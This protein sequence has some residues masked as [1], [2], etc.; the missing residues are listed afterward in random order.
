MKTPLFLKRKWA[1]KAGLLLLLTTTLPLTA[2]TTAPLPQP[3]PMNPQFL[4]YQHNKMLGTMRQQADTGHALGYI[5]P[6]VALPAPTNIARNSAINTAL[7]SSYDLRTQNKLTPVRDQGACG[8]CWAH[9]AYSSLESKL[10]PAEIAN[11][12]EA[13]MNDTVGFDFGWC[14]GGNDSM[15][16]AYLARWSGPV[17][18]VDYP[19]PYQP[20][21]TA[22]LPVRNHVQNVDFLPNRTGPLDNTAIKNALM[23]H[24]AVT[25]SFTWDD[26]NY[27]PSNKTFY[28]PAGTTSTNHEV[29]IVGWDDNYPKT[30]FKTQAPG[31]GAFIVRNS[32]GTSWGNKGYFYMSYYDKSVRWPTV[33]NNAEPVTNY[34]RVYQ[35]DPLGQTSYISYPST[36]AW[37]ANMFEAAAT[38]NSI[39]AVSFYTMEPNTSYT[40]YVYNNAVAG[41]PRSGKLVATSQGSIT[42]AGYHTVKLPTP[43]TVTP[44]KLFS[45]VIQ[46]SG[47]NLVPVEMPINGY[48]SQATAATGQSFVST[49]GT[50]WSDILAIASWTNNT[51]VCVKAFANK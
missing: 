3:A 12:S 7:P 23:T 38:T 19:T 48:S 41:Q 39:K 14:E 20:M 35:Y 49:D 5:P 24:G 50:S 42:Y 46:V 32:W 47:S 4:Q 6:P 9:G 25:V 31:N 16:T 13:H 11:F 36:T 10:K 27:H 21:A 28:D 33:F 34:G 44:G 40:V 22:N 51:N 8:D 45:V 17:N 15:S 1:T 18:D 2:G 30:K 29:A 43:A 37:F 26:A